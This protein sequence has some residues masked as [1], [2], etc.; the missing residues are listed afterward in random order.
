MLSYT[1]NE[2][3]LLVITF[4]VFFFLLELGLQLK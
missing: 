4:V 2:Q 3:L 1:D